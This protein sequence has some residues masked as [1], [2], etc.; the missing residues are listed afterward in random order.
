MK[1]IIDRERLI[2]LLIAE[3]N[4]IELERAGVDNWHGYGEGYREC[5]EEFA[6]GRFSEEELEGIMY[7]DIAILDLD[8]YEEYRYP[9]AQ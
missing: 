6:R 1:Y 2:E 8:D 9:S 7:K 3:M 4:L 5:I